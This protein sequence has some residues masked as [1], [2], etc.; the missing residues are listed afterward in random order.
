MLL[1]PTADIDRERLLARSRSLAVWEGPASSPRAGAVTAIAH[2]GDGA[3][4][5]IAL[6]VRIAPFGATIELIDDGSRRRVPAWSTGCSASASPPRW[7][8]IG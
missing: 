2:S 3:D 8:L 5:A 6:G 4:A 1:S 7:C